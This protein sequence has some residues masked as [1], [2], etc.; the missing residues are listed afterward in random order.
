MSKVKDKIK[1]TL[2][3]ASVTI[4]SNGAYWLEWTPKP[5]LPVIA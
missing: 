2:R 3:T 1:V 4:S 5:T